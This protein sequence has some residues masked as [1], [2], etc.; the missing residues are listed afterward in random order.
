MKIIYFSTDCKHPE[1][2]SIV[3][4]PKLNWKSGYPKIAP[5][6]TT[7]AGYVYSLNFSSIIPSWEDKLLNTLFV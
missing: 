6:P 2:D 4:L 7:N 5:I 3:N 1:L